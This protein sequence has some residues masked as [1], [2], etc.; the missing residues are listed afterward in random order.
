MDRAAYV[1]IDVLALKLGEAREDSRAGHRQSCECSDIEGVNEHDAVGHL[2]FDGCGV[3][4]K[5]QHPYLDE[6]LIKLRL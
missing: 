2:H 6:S 4:E 3:D 1:G 5:D